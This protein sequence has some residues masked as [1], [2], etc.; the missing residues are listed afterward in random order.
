MFGFFKRSKAPTN[1]KESA[2]GRAVY[3]EGKKSAEFSKRDYALFADEGYRKNV[4]AYQAIDKTAKAVASIP[5]I[6][7]DR[8]DKELKNHPIAPI[9]KRPNP[10]QSRSEYI[11]D[12]VGFYRITG[13]AY[14]ERTTA[15]RKLQELYVLRSDRMHVIPGESGLPRGYVYKVGQQTPIPFDF[16][17]KNGQSDVRHIKTFNPLDD[18]YGMSP[19]EA[20]AFGVDIHNESNAHNMGLLQNGANP[21]GILEMPADAS[22]SEEEYNRL[23]VDIDERMSGAANRGRPL[24][25]E[26]GM[27]WQSIS[28]SPQALDIINQKN[29]SARDISLALSV[30]PLLL[31]IPGDSTYSNYKEARLAFYEETVIPLAEHIVAEFNVWLEPFL[32]GAYICLDLEECP[33]IVERRMMLWDMADKST[34]L[35]LNE[36]RELKGYEPVEYGDVIYAPSGL[37]PLDAGL[38]DDDES[39]NPE[40]DARNAYGEDE[41]DEIDDDDTES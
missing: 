3:I 30:P 2:T 15:G 16:D 18:W 25:G 38:V 17:S 22:L 11:Q 29:T 27:K 12:L 33:P 24:I 7:K 34:D 40:E 14:A 39:E 32:Q 1:Q 19:L 20:A 9:L 4:V 35:K 41:G 8:N 23:K 28:F 31:N 10:L 13:N 21:S 6:I 37:M 26:G 36:R 5:W